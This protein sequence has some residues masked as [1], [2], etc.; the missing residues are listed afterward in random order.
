MT[1]KRSPVTVDGI[2]NKGTTGSASEPPKTAPRTHSTASDDAYS[3]VA[4][5]FRKT[6]DNGMIWNAATQTFEFLWQ[7]PQDVK[8]HGAVASGRKYVSNLLYFLAR[9]VAEN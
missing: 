1:K 9:Q 4:D 8:K 5:K 3:F 2:R 6:G 7:V